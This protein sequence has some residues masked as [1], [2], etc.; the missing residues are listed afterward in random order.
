[1]AYI[2]P[3]P[4]FYPPDGVTVNSASANLL[5]GASEP[6]L[7]ENGFVSVI[8]NLR[9]RVTGITT[10]TV[11]A[12]DSDSLIPTE[13]AVKAY[14]DAHSESTALIPTAIAY[15]DP[16]TIPTSSLRYVVDNTLPNTSR[17]VVA[18]PT[19]TNSFHVAVDELLFEARLFTN[20]SIM[21]FFANSTRM[22]SIAPDTNNGNVPA[23]WLRNGTKYNT[24]R[25]EN[26]GDLSFYSPV[27]NRVRF[28][29]SSTIAIDSSIDTGN[30]ATALVVSGG[31]TINKRLWFPY[32]YLQSTQGGIWYQFRLYPTVMASNCSFEINSDSGT[33]TLYKY[34]ASV[35]DSRFHINNFGLGVSIDSD[36][37]Q[38][39]YANTPQLIINYGGGNNTSFAVSATGDMTIDCSGNDLN[40]ASTDMVHVL[41]TTASTSPTTGA[42]VVSGGV[43]IQGSINAS[44]VM[45][46]VGTTAPQF[47]VKYDNS[48]VTTFGVSS[49]GDM[50]IDCSGDD[51]NFASS[52]MVHVLN[53]TATT[54]PTTGALVVSGG[55]G[56]QNIN[57]NNITCTG[58]TVNG[59]E[60]ITYNGPGQQLILA[61]TWPSAQYSMIS[62]L[63]N[64]TTSIGPFPVAIES[65]TDSTS[66][67]TGSLVT[68]GGIA[69]AKNAFIGGTLTCLSTNNP[70]FSISRLGTNFVNFRVTNT[71]DL[72]IDCDGNDLNFSST[73]QIHVLNTTA[74]TSTTTGAL[75]VSGGVGIEGSINARGV[76]T[77]VGTTTPQ[78]T[79]K[80]DDTN[81]SAFAC[82]STGDLTINCTGDDLNFASSDMVHVLNTTA[83]TSTTAAAFTVDGGIGC[84]E[85]I[86]AGGGIFTSTTLVPQLKVAYD[87]THYADIGITNN[88]ELTVGATS[89][90]GALRLIASNKLFV[91]DTTASTS[92]STGCTIISGG[93]GIAGSVYTG[94]HTQTNTFALTTSVTYNIDLTGQL[95]NFSGATQAA[96]NTD[97][98]CWLLPKD[99]RLV[100]NLRLPNNYVT[101]SSIV[102]TIGL[103]KSTTNL[104]EAHFHL[105]IRRM[106][107]NVQDNNVF[108]MAMTSAFLG[109]YTDTAENFTMGTMT[110]TGLTQMPMTLLCTLYRSNDASD[111][112]PDSIWLL[113]FGLDIQINK[114]G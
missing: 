94:G 29:G 5:Y 104:G 7:V 25:M 49:V 34:A 20:A 76:M 90:G 14:V 31:A 24:L 43:G 8:N 92:T 67:T 97:Y 65:V 86:I 69:A 63:T 70:Q 66:I 9:Q 28:G 15:G 12:D 64:G 106:A 100:V 41:N 4:D 68:P 72:T 30:N 84:Q 75:V 88:N 6:I 93:V 54:S 19:L 82:S 51:I 33:A 62:C 81:N 56:C 55:I 37:L 91:D 111:T 103:M 83:A 87:G 52:D 16:L 22:V 1:M 85:K 58:D 3:P 38:L 109:G 113:S 73:D 40:F 108:S 114:L 112:Y 98:R 21:D 23:I 107:N 42:F 27:A 95:V 17:L 57:C 102:P 53:T 77:I 18:G 44:G 60:L 48:N 101:Q 78:F 71:G 59:Q 39:N 2:E 79:V 96:L 13:H 36:Q 11:L 26:G 10:S 32:H 105:D 99:S 46:I 45:T 61:N 35:G 80:Y 47:T 50:S 89:P 110:M 74:S